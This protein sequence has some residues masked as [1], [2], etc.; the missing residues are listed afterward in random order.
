MTNLEEA[1][2]RADEIRRSTPSITP[3]RNRR[4]MYKFLV[5]AVVITVAIIILLLSIRS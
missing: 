3:R 2:R 1:R 5:V 4:G